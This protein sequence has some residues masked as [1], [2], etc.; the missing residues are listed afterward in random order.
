MTKRSRRTHSP[1]FKAKVA[2][3][4]LRGEKTLAELAQFFDVHANQITTWKGQLLEGA[5]GV[6]GSGPAEPETAA[7]DL[8]TLHAKIGQ[9]S[10]ENDFLAGAL[11]KAGMLS[12]KR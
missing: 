10:L 11:T 2:L 6:F 5:A 12:T 9:L 7:V 4:A 1:A 8:K 3:A